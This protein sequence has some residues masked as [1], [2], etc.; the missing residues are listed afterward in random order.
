MAIVW[1]QTINGSSQLPI[2]FTDNIKN[3]LP[4]VYDTVDIG[5]N[6]NTD[7]AVN[8]G[9]VYVIWQDDNSGT[10][11]FR[12]GTYTPSVSISEID[13][14]NFTIF[15]IPTRDILSIEFKSKIQSAEITILNIL[16]EGVLKYKI[17]DTLS[18]FLPIDDL[19][20]GVYFIM[21]RSGNNF[22]TKKFVKQ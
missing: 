3:G 1:K 18:T 8:K 6:T 19:A 17:T 13:Q 20:N 9:K 21:V 22:Y 7:V 16:G 4:T 12:N 2:L 14:N 11:K 15:P 10:V 5:D